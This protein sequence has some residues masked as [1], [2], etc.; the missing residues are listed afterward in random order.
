M[1]ALSLEESLGREG[2]GF[3]LPGQ[4]VRRNLRLEQHTVCKCLHLALSLFF[5]LEVKFSIVASSPVQL[6][7]SSLHD[8]ASKHTLP[9]FLATLI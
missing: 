7:V 5:P 8:V 9:N 2:F 3:A 6:P 1:P 4:H